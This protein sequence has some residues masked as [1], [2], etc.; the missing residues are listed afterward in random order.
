AQTAKLKLRT[1]NERIAGEWRAKRTPLITPDSSRSGTPGT[2]VPR[3]RCLRIATIMI[4]KKNALPTKALPEPSHAVTAPA[5][6][7]PI[8]RD[9]ER[10]GAKRDGARQ[11]GARDELVDARLLRRQIER[12]ARA[13]DKSEEQ[14]QCRAD[15]A[16]ERGDAQQQRGGEQTDLGDENQPPPVDD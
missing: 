1:M 9:V 12:E 13:D 3:P 2:A 15:H 8:A 4:T 5:S 16:R 6:A 10:D 14:Q 7:G 11:L